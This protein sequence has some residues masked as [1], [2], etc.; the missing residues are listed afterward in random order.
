M[1]S[2]AC[3]ESIVRIVPFWMS[4]GFLRLTEGARIGEPDQD[5]GPI[6]PNERITPFSFGNQDGQPACSDA[7][8]LAADSRKSDLHAIRDA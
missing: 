4:L 2:T 3:E 7:Y 8:S 5:K 6:S 1:A